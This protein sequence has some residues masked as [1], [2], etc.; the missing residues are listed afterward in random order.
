MFSRCVMLLLPSAGA[1]PRRPAQCR[2][3]GLPAVAAA[4][5][6]IVLNWVC[7]SH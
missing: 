6:P 1:A 2:L 7:R 3:G 4:V 5:S